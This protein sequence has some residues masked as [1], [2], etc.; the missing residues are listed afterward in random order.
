MWFYDGGFGPHGS[1][2]AST[3]TWR[4]QVSHVMAHSSEWA[5]PSANSG[6]QRLRWTSLV[7]EDFRHACHPSSQRGTGAIRR[8]MGGGHLETPF[9]GSV[10]T[11]LY[12]LIPLAYFNLYSCKKPQSSIWQYSVSSVSPFSRFL[13]LR[14]VLRPCEL[15]NGIKREDGLVWTLLPLVLWFI[16]S[17]SGWSF[18]ISSWNC[19]KDYKFWY[20]KHIEQC[21]VYK[22]LSKCWLLLY[23]CHTHKHRQIIF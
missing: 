1:S 21:M 17:Q 5:S 3:K 13:N 6:H 14:M 16:N 12:M 8:S 2:S 20:V 23:E 22:V 11:L 19:W 15:A 7:D 4:L 18:C 9:F 10:W